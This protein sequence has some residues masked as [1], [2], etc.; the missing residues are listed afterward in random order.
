MVFLGKV[1]SQGPTGC[2]SCAEMVRVICQLRITENNCSASEKGTYIGANNFS[3]EHQSEGF[4]PRRSYLSFGRSFLGP[5]LAHGKLN[6]GPSG[7]SE[8]LC[9]SK[10]AKHCLSCASLEMSRE[11]FCCCL[12]FLSS[13]WSIVASTTG[14]RTDRMD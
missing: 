12:V 14:V 10:S 9:S 8:S 5:P 11:T 1:L 6:V 2:C 3:E 13:P 4:R 7:G